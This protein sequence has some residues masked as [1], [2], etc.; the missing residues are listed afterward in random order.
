MCNIK[1]NDCLGQF[2]VFFANTIKFLIRLGGGLLS[3]RSFLVAVVCSKLN[4]VTCQ[5]THGVY[6]F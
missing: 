3:C 6:L 5:L 2:F 1:K 4:K